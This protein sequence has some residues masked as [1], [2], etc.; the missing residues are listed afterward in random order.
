MPI[1]SR[2]Y[3]DVV[4]ALRPL[5]K[6]RGPTLVAI[7][8]RLGSGKT[9]LGRYLAWHFNIALIETDFFLKLGKGFSY[10]ESELR[11]AISHRVSRGL[12]VFVEGAAIAQLLPQVAHA[13]AFTIY[14]LNHGPSSRD[15]THEYV[16]AYEKNYD[17]IGNADFVV[18]LSH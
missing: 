9:T 18:E 12:P 1:S 14:V 5:L 17:P 2:S 11:R 4:A 15:N 6:P 10:R 8:G 7:D 13:A 3:K 16:V